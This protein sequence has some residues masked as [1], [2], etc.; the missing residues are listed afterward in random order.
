MVRLVLLRLSE[1]YFRH[2]WLYL[3][4]ILIM[5]GFAAVYFFTRDPVYL[6]GGV[7]Y[8]K[9]ES[10]LSTLTSVREVPFTWETASQDTAGEINDLL[11]TDAFIRAVIRETDL[12][13]GM[14]RGKNEVDQIYE[15]ARGSIWTYTIGSN[16][17]GVNAG[18]SDAQIA[19]QLV[20]A[21]LNNYINWK[22]N[23]D[24]AESDVAQQFFIDLVDRYEAER[25]GWRAE[26]KAY[27]LEHPAPLQ[28]ERPP[29]ELL[30]IDRIQAELQLAGTRYSQA[31]QRV[32]DA[33]LANSQTESDVR[34][35]YFL[36]DAPEL[37]LEPTSSLKETAI[38]G[39]V[40]VA[41]GVILSV[42][43]VT[44]SA[45]L[46]QSFRFPID[47]SHRLELPVLATVSDT[48]TRPKWYQR[49]FRRN[50]RNDEPDRG[51]DS[52][53][54]NEIYSYPPARSNGRNGNHRPKKTVEE[55]QADRKPVRVS[56]ITNSVIEPVETTNI[57]PGDYTAAGLKGELSSLDL[58]ADEIESLFYKEVTGKNRKTVIRYLDSLQKNGS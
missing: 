27:L 5:I 25:E 33:R 45:L 6:S 49:I 30:E 41:A 52:G 43:A 26:L 11:Q 22:I 28:G 40:F 15:D 35:T 7:L 37:P 1:S 20:N 3:L 46:D 48:R 4:P 29:E 14:D 31:L 19:Y 56:A 10:F 57:D 2:R 47:L 51:P 39:A 32:E 17:V 58:T 54:P 44:G 21:T 53:Q 16:Q 8:V 12:E 36:I 23:A 34:Q 24:L 18:H 38:D 9:K 42:L 50:R 13:E 55:S